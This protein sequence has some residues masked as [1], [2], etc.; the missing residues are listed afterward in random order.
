MK[1]SDVKG[2]ALYRHYKGGL[3]RVCGFATH[4]ETGETM[5]IY[6]DLKWGTIWARPIEM[7]CEMVGDVQRL[8]E[9]EEE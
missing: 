4:T 9:V 7:F 3:Y 6:E 8:T 2:G 1:P 5:V